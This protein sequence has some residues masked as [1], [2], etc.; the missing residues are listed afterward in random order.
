MPETPADVAVH[1]GLITPEQRDRAHLMSETSGRP[2]TDVLV[3]LGLVTVEVAKELGELKQQFGRYEL[4]KEVGRGGMGVVYKAWQPDLKRAVAVKIVTSTS[5]E[6]LKRFQ[7]EAE[8]AAKLSHPNIAPI[9]EVGNQDGRPFLAMAFIDGRTLSKCDLPL[10]RKMEILRDAARALQHAHQAGIIHRDVK[11]DN[12]MIDRQG[13]TFIM[14]FGL[15]KSIKPGSSLT[16]GGVVMGTPSYMSP[17]QVQGRTRALT[18]RSDVYSLG[19]TMYELLTGLPPFIAEDF[20]T[21]MLRVLKDDPEPP[22]HRRIGIPPDLETVCLKAMQKSPALRYATAGD[23]ADDVDRWLRGE[24]VIGKRPGAFSQATARLRRQPVVVAAALLLILVVSV[25]AVM[26][27]QA[28]KQASDSAASLL[29]EREAMKSAR[30]EYD[31]G[32]SVLDGAESLALRD[33]AGATEAAKAA[34]ARFDKAV[35]IAPTFGDAWHAR[36]RARAL[37]PTARGRDVDADFQKAVDLNPN[38]PRIYLDWGLAVTRDRLL[39]AEVFRPA[40]YDDPK[41]AVVPTPIAAMPDLPGLWTDLA[42][43]RNCLRHVAD[44]AAKPEEREFAFG[45]LTLIGDNPGVAER[46]FTKVLDTDDRHYWARTCRGLARVKTAKWNEA[47]ADLALSIREKP[48]YARSRL[49]RSVAAQYAGEWA[50][51]LEDLEWLLSREKDPAEQARLRLRRGMIL[52]FAGRPDDA[53]AEFAQVISLAPKREEAYVFRAHLLEAKGD[54]TAAAAELQKLIEA[55]PAGWTGPFESGMLAWRGGS[56]A[57]AKAAFEKALAIDPKNIR[58]VFFLA[59]IAHAT[60]APSKELFARY[61][62]ATFDSDPGHHEA[63]AMVAIAEGR[64]KEAIGFLLKAQEHAPENIALWTQLGEVHTMLKDDTAA[65]NAYSEAVKRAP[66]DAEAHVKLGHYYL[67]R[68]F[69][70]KAETELNIA[71]KLRDTADARFARGTARKKLK[72]FEGARTDFEAAAKDARF[73]DAALKE[74]EALK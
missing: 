43:A 48:A 8:T 31:A 70:D 61:A 36:G 34:L 74:L 2:V 35:A 9:Y 24:P 33:E 46:H 51:A 55:V 19:A 32:I 63:L 12:I 30:P 16:L 65:F 72:K 39:P 59:R 47:L 18:P 26:I 66:N 23:F 52:K 20:M 50:T 15:A 53:F 10:A 38:S 68:D 11:P 6:D 4:L 27:V 57:V 41:A 29:R 58:P 44:L 49:Y 22:R 3:E 5:E 45:L 73:K 42:T 17:E 40:A 71:I 60:G 1:R 14:D 67:G 64:L 37:D 69:D 56:P 21:V 62:A 25:A 54:A 7:R 13:R 28:Q